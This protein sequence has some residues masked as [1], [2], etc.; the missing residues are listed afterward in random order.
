MVTSY[1]GEW[2]MTKPPGLTSRAIC[3]N[4]GTKNIQRRTKVH[5]WQNSDFKATI[6]TKNGYNND[7]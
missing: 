4:K 5:Y 2:G 1:V 3:S 7:S 6:L